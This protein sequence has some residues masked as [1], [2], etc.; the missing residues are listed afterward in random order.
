MLRFGF[1]QKGW[2]NRFLRAAVT[3]ICALAAWF[4]IAVLIGFSLFKM[5]LQ[6]SEDAVFLIS[7]TLGGFASLAIA[8]AVF[9]GVPKYLFSRKRST[10]TDANEPT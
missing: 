6:L 4:A 1:M 5:K 10:D 2:L 8:T 9:E 3:L 7:L